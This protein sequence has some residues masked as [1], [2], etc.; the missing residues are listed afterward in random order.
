MYRSWKTQHADQ[1]QP[2]RGL[3][4]R[5]WSRGLTSIS[6]AVV[7]LVYSA[8]CAVS[9]G[10]DDSQIIAPTLLTIKSA[11]E[12]GL[13]IRVITSHKDAFV[14]ITGLPKA[15]ALSTGR[16][17]DS[18]VWAV[19]VSEL[20]ELKIVAMVTST[21]EH[22]LSLSLKTLDGG[23]LAEFQTA[24]RISPLTGDESTEET[25]NEELQTAAV[26]PPV[27]PEL[28]EQQSSN[29][30]VQSQ[31]AKADRA[32]IAAQ[33]PVISEEDMESILLLMRKGSENMQ[34]GNINVARLFYTR[35]ADKGWADAA[36]ALAR[37]Y[38]AIELEKIGAIGVDAD[39]EQAARWYKRAV[40]LGST[41][42]VAYLERFQ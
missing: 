29:Q 11:T 40:E 36:F 15:V 34:L 7:M 2:G 28:D 22:T 17:F 5:G 32:P 6:A 30:D 31:P 26:A 21:E 1:N 10:S 13:P 37:T 35:A 38:D 24:L 33:P 18:G 9:Q 16:L 25:T 23:V 27:Q 12:T 4:R 41:T 19:K 39:A 3:P 14:L 42:A 20:D 8:T